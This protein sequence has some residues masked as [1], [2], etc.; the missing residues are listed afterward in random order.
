MN[1]ISTFIELDKLYESVDT[2]DE[3]VL[4]DY[5]ILK[6]TYDT[7]RE[8][9]DKNKESGHIA[10]LL[11]ELKTKNVPFEQYIHKTDNGITIFYDKF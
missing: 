2:P 11:D 4:H 9:N 3:L 7:Y 6:N 5:G 1:I 8:F 10:E